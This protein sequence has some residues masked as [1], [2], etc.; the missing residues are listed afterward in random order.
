MCS[1]G[2]YRYRMNT[3]GPRGQ[4]LRSRTTPRCRRRSARSPVV[5]QRVEKEQTTPVP[6]PIDLR[7]GE[8]R[9]LIA[10]GDTHEGAGVGD[11]EPDPAPWLSPSMTHGV[12]RQ[13][14]DE[15]GRD[16]ELLV[17]PQMGDGGV[18]EPARFS[19]SLRSRDQILRPGG[20]GAPAAR[21]IWGT[22]PASHGRTL[23][24]GSSGRS[25]HR[26]R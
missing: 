2:A 22:Y 20:L 16:L 21:L 17:E 10:D 8:A 3:R 9:A 25:G 18:Q 7:Q 5:R 19:G 4:G 14:R 1:R 26:A 23:N 15:E 11:R 24:G 13:L 6:A 12:R